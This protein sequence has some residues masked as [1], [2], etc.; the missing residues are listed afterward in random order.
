M[1]KTEVPRQY[2]FSKQERLTGKKNIEELFKKSSSFHLYPLLFKFIPTDEQHTK[3]LISVPKKN[4]KRAVDRN[5]LKRR[6][7]EAYRLNKHILTDSSSQGLFLGLIYTSKE[8]LD[9]KYIETKLI[10][11]MNRL[12]NFKSLVDEE[13]A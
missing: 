7:R 10:S 6:I 2:T 1:T 4:H 9:Y 8:I 3:V 12:V 11:G 5:L 13:K